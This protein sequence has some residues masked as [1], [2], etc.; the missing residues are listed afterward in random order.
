MACWF[1][2]GGIRVGERP[3]D[4]AAADAHGSPDRPSACSLGGPAW[5]TRALGSR[6]RRAA[7]G[8][9]TRINLA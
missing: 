4:L 7:P 9:D 2:F 5:P 6:G 1:G 3:A 8:Y